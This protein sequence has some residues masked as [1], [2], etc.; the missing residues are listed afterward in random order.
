MNM[1]SLYL[2]E[3]K[4]NAHSVGDVLD[5]AY[6]TLRYGAS[7][8]NYAMFGFKNLTGK[9]R[10]TYVTNR[11][12]RKMIKKY[13]SAAHIDIFEDKAKFATVF[14]DF[15]SRSFVITDNLSW[16]KFGS[17]I[18]GINN[19]GGGI[20]RFICKP[21][22][23]SQGNGIHVYENWA[24][25]KKLYDEI[26]SLGPGYILE[27]WIEQHPFISEMYP[28]A[29]NCLRLITVY[30]DGKANI[31][32][33]GLTLG[34]DSQI[35]NGS[36]K[37]IICPVDFETGILNQPGA[38]SHGGV[39][40]KHP[41]TGAQILGVQLP[42][43]DE[44]TLM[45]DKAAALVPEVGYVGWDIAI[46]PSG[47]IIIEGNTTPGYRYYQLPV[48]KKDGIGNLPRYKKYL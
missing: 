5:I 18:S 27:Q 40:E 16:E 29:V 28:K 46:T 6:C 31:L 42:F 23:G 30:K 9:Q 15:F 17:F 33:G 34:V 10:A 32:A 2:K 14:S 48:H 36:H 47:P 38:D 45:L 7:P 41:V 35:A 25:D 8:V 21:N 1:L 3:L 24:D 4:E 37:S 26:I 11:M 22:G 13:N 12:S 43:W 20:R 44:I 39:Y 19:A